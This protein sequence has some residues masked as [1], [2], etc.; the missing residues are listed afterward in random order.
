MEADFWLKKWESNEIGFHQD[1]VNEMIK[2]CWPEVGA[3]QGGPVLAPLCGK[4]LD[5]RW[6]AEQGHSVIGL[7]I[8]PLACEAFC[9]GLKLKP[10]IGTAGALRSLTAGAYRLLQGDFFSAT[11]AELGSVSAFY[12]RAAWVAMPPAMQPA[13]VSR[14]LSLLAPGAVGLINSLEYPPELMDGPPFSIS[15]T[16]LRE[17]LPPPSRLQRLFAGEVNLKGTNL[18]GRGLTGLVETAYRVRVAG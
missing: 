9:E 5:M 12:D 2:A 7:E 15:E 16:R 1:T 18:E 4:S 8:S 17:L 3:P 6:L 11:A 10:R 13:Y 14:L